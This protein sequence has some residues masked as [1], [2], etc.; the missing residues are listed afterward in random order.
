MFGGRYYRPFINMEPYYIYYYIAQGSCHIGMWHGANTL[1]QI[2]THFFIIINLGLLRQML[3]PER[4]YTYRYTHALTHLSVEL[5]SEEGRLPLGKRAS[6]RART[7][8]RT[9]WTPASP[10]ARVRGHC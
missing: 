9:A 3:Q 7:A 5:P 4:T 10:R 8:A 1:C 2:Y 6:R